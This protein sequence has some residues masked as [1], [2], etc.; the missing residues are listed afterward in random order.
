VTIEIARQDEDNRGPHEYPVRFRVVEI[1]GGLAIVVAGTLALATLYVANAHELGVGVLHS[2]APIWGFVLIAWSV[3]LIDFTRDR[4]ASIAAVILFL[5]SVAAMAAI[6][7]VFVTLVHEPADLLGPLAVALALI[8]I[9]L[10]R[11][12][13]RGKRWLAVPV[14]ILIT[15]G[16]IVTGFHGALPWPP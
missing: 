16:L 2:F 8:G 4:V 13:R 9:V 12:R 7:S 3:A 6:S 15:L 1:L 10:V 11:E 5:G 14:I